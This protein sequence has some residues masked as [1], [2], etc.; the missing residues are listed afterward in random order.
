MDTSVKLNDFA[1]TMQG[2]VSA[3]KVNGSDYKNEA[4]YG[5]MQQTAQ[6]QKTNTKSSER[7]D[8]TSK[9]ETTSNDKKDSVDSKED[10]AKPETQ[11]KD[12]TN[13]EDTEEV[14]DNMMQQIDLAMFAAAVNT[15]IVPVENAVT[16]VNVETPV[17]ET[18]AIEV[19]TTNGNAD[20]T[21]QQ[22][23]AVD[24]LQKQTE[25]V[26]Q[27]FSKEVSQTEQNVT[28][29]AP[30]EVKVEK[31]VEVQPKQEQ[32]EKVETVKTEVKT[33]NVKEAEQTV[34]VEETTG[35][36]EKTDTAQTNTSEKEDTDVF[37]EEIPTTSRRTFS[38]DVINVKVGD[39]AQITDSSMAE[40]VSDKMLAKF[41]QKQNE[42]E[43]QLMPKELGKIVIKL[44][45]ENG[46]THVQMFA[47]NAKTSSLLAEKAR[48]ISSI[49][50]QNT[51]NETNVEVVDQKEMQAQDQN[52]EAKG[53]GFDRQ[54]EEQQKQHQ[55]KMQAQQ[56]VD[57]IQQMR[58]GL[59]NRVS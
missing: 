14:K 13:N 47:E 21:Q 33:E 19:Q 15:N 11:Q 48:E 25:E 28:K 7:K 29:E 4:F 53:D 43:I 38:D 42:F 5:F 41:A 23:V 31:A 49:I 20:T 46:Q 27:E 9:K 37:E 8:T 39:N 56:S 6:T 58:L 12:N 54:K 17:V 59:W 26:I 3:T 51:G 44:F 22:T 36:E 55:Q 1:T 34:V 57:F 30:E 32:T 24:T 52:K 45:V 18:S 35:T 16:E 50:E 2:Q 10:V 40:K